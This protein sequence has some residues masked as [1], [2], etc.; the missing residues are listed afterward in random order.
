MAVEGQV[1]ADKYR[2]ERHLGSGGFASVWAARN[3]DLG[4]PVALKILSDA[5]S[6]S[7]ETVL[8]FVREAKL[9]SRAI[10][11]TIVQVEDIHQTEAG[12]P[13]MV[14]ELLEGRSLL[15]E[16]HEREVMSLKETITIIRPTLKGLAAAHELGIIHRDVKPGNIFLVE[17][18]GDVPGVKILDLGLAKDADTSEG[19]TRTGIVMGTPDYLAPEL[20]TIDQKHAWSTA[21]DIFALGVIAYR[22]LSGRRPLEGHVNADSSP[23]GFVKRANF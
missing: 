22:M 13:F 8:R 21:A 11:P 17:N 16:L 19:L 1:L 20:L 6:H 23:M 12:V 18:E 4:R 7:K 9:S 10:H 3:I 2:L 15:K 14:M 5:L